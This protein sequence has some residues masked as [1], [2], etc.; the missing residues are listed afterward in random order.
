MVKL[1]KKALKEILFRCRFEETATVVNVMRESVLG[2]PF[3]SYDVMKLGD[4]Q[5]L[6]GDLNSVVDCTSVGLLT[7]A[8]RLYGWKVKVVEKEEEDEQEQN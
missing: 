4:I 1:T 5:K 7:S 8:L 6:S 2:E 3:S